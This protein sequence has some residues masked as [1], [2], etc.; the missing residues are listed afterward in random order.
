MP[1]MRNDSH[2]SLG[3]CSTSVTWSPQAHHVYS[4]LKRRRKDRFHVASTWNTCIVFVAIPCNITQI[5]HGLPLNIKTYSPEVSNIQ[6]HEANSEQNSILGVLPR[7][8][9]VCV[10]CKIDFG[11]TR[12]VYLVKWTEKRVVLPDCI[13]C[14][15]LRRL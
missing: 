12:R 5:L 8:L 14:E 7:Y 4:T 11:F 10:L 15:T 2:Y 3:D 6:R 1:C 9:Y 13:Y